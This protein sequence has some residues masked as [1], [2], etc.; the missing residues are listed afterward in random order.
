[1]QT[2][3]TY[4]ELQMFFEK[5]DTLVMLVSGDGE[6]DGSWPWGE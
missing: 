2:K 1:M 4:E 3:K 6:N 5:W